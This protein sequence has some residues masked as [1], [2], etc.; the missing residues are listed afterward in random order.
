MQDGQIAAWTAVFLGLAALAAGIGEWRQAGGWDRMME[1]IERSRALQYLGGTACVAIGGAIYIANPLYGND[2]LSFLLGMIGG[3]IVL[4]GLILLALPDR[5][6][7]FAF[8][9][10]EKA[11]RIGPGVAV[12]IGLALFLAGA[13]RV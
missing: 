7:P 11:D 13:V 6:L 2:W 3:L 10:V 5:F 8:A 9:L 12:A 1:E 4:E